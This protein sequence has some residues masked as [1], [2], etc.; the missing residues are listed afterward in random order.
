M[1]S[2]HTDEVYFRHSTWLP[3]LV[4]GI[5]YHAAILAAASAMIGP[6]SRRHSIVSTEGYS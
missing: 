6:H 2:I 5:G 1:A 3:C 4:D